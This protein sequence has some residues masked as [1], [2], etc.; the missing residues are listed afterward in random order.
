MLL[1]LLVQ[2]TGAR[3]VLSSRWRITQLTRSIVEKRLAVDGLPLYSCTPNSVNG[4]ADN[5]ALE[6]VEWLE[7]AEQRGDIVAEW[8]V[9]DDEPVEMLDQRMKDHW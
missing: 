4:G 9:L 5:R 1:K 2:T 7:S 8:V 3:I 6:I